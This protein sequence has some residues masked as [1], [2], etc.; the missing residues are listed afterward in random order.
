MDRARTLASLRVLVIVVIVA[1]L[2]AL[3][4][5]D[6]HVAIGI[7]VIAAAAWALALLHGLRDADAFEEQP[8]VYLRPDERRALQK[9]INLR[10]SRPPQP[11]ADRP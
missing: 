1:G 6:W 11:M 5:P 7:V 4:R 10:R 8:G 2:V 9:Q 3:F